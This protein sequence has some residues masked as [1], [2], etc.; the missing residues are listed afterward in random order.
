MF[1]HDIWSRTMT[2]LPETLL[3]F[4]EGELSPEEARKVAAEVANDPSLAAHVENH[5]ALKARLQAAS[6]PVSEPSGGKTAPAGGRGALPPAAPMAPPR[7]AGSSWLPAGAMAIGI[8][9][10]L[11]LA[12]SLRP[13]TEIRSDDGTVVAQG[14]LAQALSVVISMDS[15][16]AAFG[17][18]RVGDSFF[19][20]DGY[21][22]RNFTTAGGDDSSA[23]AGIACR[24]GEEWRIRVLA[25]TENP[26][27]GAEKPGNKAAP[28]PVAVR[29]TLSAM[30]VGN[31]LDAEGER[32][33]RA[34]GWLV[35]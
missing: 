15:N 28:V 26:D 34:Q 3:A 13:G 12:L 33:A 8:V 20:S 17:P 1:A 4:V 21:F 27:T 5:K 29:D 16:A 10:G 6:V 18:A 2:V 25:S 30:M 22:C 24:E 11:L 9:L 35:R 19:S 32:A 7:R 14:T 31:P 23:L